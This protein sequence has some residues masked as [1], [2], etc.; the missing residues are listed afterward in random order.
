MIRVKA[1]SV[2]LIEPPVTY[3]YA[4]TFRYAV[5]DAFTISSI[6]ISPWMISSE[7]LNEM[8]KHFQT[9]IGTNVLGAS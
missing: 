5:N 9:R 7:M 6:K 1:N 4:Y 3:A 2:Q 8:C